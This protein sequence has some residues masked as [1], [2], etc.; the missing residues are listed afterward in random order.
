MGPG[1]WSVL[2]QMFDWLALTKRLYPPLIS[3]GL[4]SNIFAS[5]RQTYDH[6]S[7]YFR[8]VLK[9]EQDQ[10]VKNPRSRF[11]W[12][13]AKGGK[14][15][16]ASLRLC[17]FRDPVF[18]SLRYVL[19]VDWWTDGGSCPPGHWSVASQMFDWLALIKRLYSPLYLSRPCV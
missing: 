9:K 11:K 19:N 5:R 13:K 8:F 7:R 10:P 3:L 16:S 2:P 12:L 1:H 4:A 18:P 6:E 17:C 14:D 15:P